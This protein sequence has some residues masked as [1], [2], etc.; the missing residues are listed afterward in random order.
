MTDTQ[1]NGAT[2]QRD[3]SPAFPLM[4]LEAALKRLAEFDNHFKRSPARPDRIGEAW[5]IKGKAYIDRSVAALKYFG[6][7]DYQGSGSARQVVVSEE[8][9]RYLRAQQEETKQQVVRAAALRPKQIAHFWDR[10]GSDRPADAACID[11]LTLE[12][13]FSDKGAKDFLWVYDATIS[14]A[15]LADSDKT[16]DHEANEVPMTPAGH[17]VAPQGETRSSIGRRLLDESPTAVPYP[18]PKS[19]MLQEIFNLDEGPVTLSFPSD[20]SQDSYED[21]KDQLELFLRRAQRR[22]RSKES[23][24]SAVKEPEEEEDEV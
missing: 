10:W 9:R 12:N 21:L 22:A 24:R 11:E 18:P 20:L 13:G 16:V 4:P 6:L 14:F 8:G 19:P 1:T 7:L 2:G 3:R 23:P 15:G 5:G 17:G